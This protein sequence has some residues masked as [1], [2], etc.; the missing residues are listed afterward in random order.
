MLDS[1]EEANDHIRMYSTNNK[2]YGIFRKVKEIDS[3]EKEMIR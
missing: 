3:Y 2:G 1:K